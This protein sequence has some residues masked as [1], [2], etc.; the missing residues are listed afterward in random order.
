M[1]SLHHIHEWLSPP[2]PSTNHEGARD[3]CQPY[4]G[5]WFTKGKSFSKW[6]SLGCSFLWLHGIPGC[7]KT[8][9][10]STII[11]DL[12]DQFQDDPKAAVVYFYFDFND[13]EKQK[14]ESL[15]SSLL[16]QLASQC[17]RH[18]PE[19]LKDLYT[20]SKDIS[21]E[22]K[23]P[24]TYDRMRGTLVSLVSEFDQV[25]ICLD[26]LDECTNRD[27]LLKLLNYILEKSLAPLHILATSR[28]ERDLEVSLTKMAIECI[29]LQNAG[30][31]A[32]IQQYIEDQLN[33][34]WRL[35]EPPRKVKE[36]I[37]TTLIENAKGMYDNITLI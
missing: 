1:E 9:L 37:K 23:L 26:A 19:A 33:K 7:G 18:V 34:G 30:V 8:I 27:R 14:P 25:Y 21:G 31:D 35:T 11:Q 28:K 24:P 6:K 10:S 2:N 5:L 13:Q 29:D 16:V 36:N 22:K 32:D 4:T 20:S 15:L 12:I 17:R 3:L